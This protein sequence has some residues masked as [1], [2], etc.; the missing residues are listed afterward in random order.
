[1]A[2]HQREDS[3]GHNHLSTK[4]RGVRRMMKGNDEAQ[5]ILDSEAY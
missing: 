2:E 1:M 4:I 5:L 3:S